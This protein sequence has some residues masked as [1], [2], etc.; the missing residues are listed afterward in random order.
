[1]PSEE[2]KNFFTREFSPGTLKIIIIILFTLVFISL[3]LNGY[4]IAQWVQT[5]QQVIQ[6]VQ[7]FSPVARDALTRADT[8]LEAFQNSTLEFVVK[9][10]QELPIDVE[11]PINKR[12]EVPINVT[13]PISKEIQTTVMM[14]PFQAGLEIPVD[15]NVPVNVEVPI[16]VVLPVEID[17]TI[18][19]S[20]TVPVKLDVPIAVDINDTDLVPYIEQL[21]QGISALG[22]SLNQMISGLEE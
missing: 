11:I 12:V 14:D 20:T 8:E 19:I 18:P 2:K 16:D 17:E 3:G 5:R 10:D 21:R 9:I 15:I 7:Q 4:L 13:V 1:M 6:T 22:D